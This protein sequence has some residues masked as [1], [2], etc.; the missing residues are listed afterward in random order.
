MKYTRDEIYLVMM[1]DYSL[2]GE[3]DTIR[4]TFL[5]KEHA[6]EYAEY[7]GKKAYVRSWYDGCYELKLDWLTK[8]VI[9]FIKKDDEDE[10]KKHG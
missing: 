6:E 5:T 4:G 2:I 10:D 3:P 8:E 9:P 7:L 1:E